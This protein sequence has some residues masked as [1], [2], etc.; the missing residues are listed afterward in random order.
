MKKIIPILALLFLVSLIAF[1][2]QAVSID[3]PLGDKTF[4]DIIDSVIN[5]IFFFGIAVAPLM[6]I[7]AG[8]MILTARDD[9]EQVKRGRQ[10]ILYVMI[11]LGII[12]FAKGIVSVLN[13]VLG[14]KKTTI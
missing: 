4:T 2:V 1:P 11:G 6:V 14:V 8:L 9:A 3:N 13:Q 12:L 7:I 10:I 5:F